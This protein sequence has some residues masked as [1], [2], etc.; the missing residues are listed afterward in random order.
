MFD[1]LD[2][3][4]K[5]DEISDAPQMIPFLRELSNDERIPLIARNHASRIVKTIEKKKEEKK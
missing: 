2:S 4:V 3:L 1:A 5:R